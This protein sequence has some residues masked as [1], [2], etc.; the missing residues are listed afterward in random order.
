MY[1]LCE[2]V[3]LQAHSNRLATSEAGKILSDALA[4]NS[5]LVELDV[6]R[7]NW[8]A[9]TT[10]RTAGDGG[11]ADSAEG[12]GAAFVEALT[13]GLTTNQALSMLNLADN[14]IEDWVSKLRVQL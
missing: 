10:D 11:A 3:Q 8:E 2:L 7:N 5:T 12:D 14:K 1:S 9:S 4:A 6:S 13:V